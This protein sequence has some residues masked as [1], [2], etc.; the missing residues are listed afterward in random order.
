MLNLTEIFEVLQPPE[1]TPLSGVRFRAVPIPGNEQHRLGKDVK[2]APA[3][4]LS[5]TAS[6]D[7]KRPAPIALEHLSVQHDVRCEISH[8]DGTTEEGLFALVQCRSDD[9]AL[10]AYFL[11]VAGAIVALLG[12]TPS[13]SDVSRAISRLVELFRAMSL[14]PRKSVQGLW[15]ELLIIAQARSPEALVNAWHTLP[16]DRY[17]FSAGSQRVEVKSGSGRVRDHYFTVEQ[18]HP[19]PGTDVLVASLFVERAGGGTSLADLVSQV[20]S[21]VSGNPTL[22]LHIDQIV[23]LTLGN[24]WR[25]A[26]EERFD[27]ELAEH[28]LEFFAPEDIPKVGCDLPPGVSNVRFRSDLTGVPAADR[29]H[30]RDAGGLFRAVLRR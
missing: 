2:G 30:Y 24:S 25:S 5:V 26:Q 11:R 29:T 14:A 4:L 8:P 19:P 9:P 22:L 28:S 27:R 20:R 7:E 17:D 6:P 1:G 12:A 15:A 10:R 23:G 21:A 3:L 18:L 13:Y 16:E